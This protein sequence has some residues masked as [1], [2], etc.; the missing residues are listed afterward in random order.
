MGVVV[1]SVAGRVVQALDL[2]AAHLPPPGQDWG[3][4]LCSVESW[5]CPPFDAAARQVVAGGLR[6]AELV[7]PDLHHLLWT[8]GAARPGFD[9]GHADG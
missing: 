9:E 5:P 1:D 7:P 8:P 3:C 6:L 4:R 2:V